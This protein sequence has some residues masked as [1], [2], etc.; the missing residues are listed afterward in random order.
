VCVIYQILLCESDCGMYYG[1]SCVVCVI[2]IVCVIVCGIPNPPLRIGLWNV[3]RCVMC[4]VSHMYSVCHMYSVR[5][6]YSM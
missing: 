2:C 1:V 4:S 3:L 6:M 5:H